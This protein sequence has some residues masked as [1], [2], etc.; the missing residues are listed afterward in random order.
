[1]ADEFAKP[2]F[3]GK[4]FQNP[5]SFTTWKDPPSAGNPGSWR[6]FIKWKWDAKSTK[7]PNLKVLDQT[8]PVL[9]PRFQTDSR[10]SA[11]WLGH[12]TLF[13]RID[14][15]SVLTDPV[16]AMFATPSFLPFFKFCPRFRPPPCKIEELPKIDIVLI[17][18]NHYDHLDVVA[19][20]ELA[21]RF[22]HI[23]WV[24]PLGLKQLVQ[25]ETN[26]KAVHEMN[27]GDRLEL[28]LNERTFEVFSVPAQHWSQRN[29]IDRNTSLW[30][31]WLTKGP[32]HK[33]FFAGDTGLCA[34][35]FRKL[36][37]IHGPIDLSAIPI[38]AYEPRWFLAPQHIDP[39]E[40]V[41][42]HELVKSKKSIAV[43]WGTFE[44]GSYETYLEPREMLTKAVAAAGIEPEAF[45]TLKHGESWRIE[46]RD[47]GTDA[48]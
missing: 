44:M 41:Q 17:S 46:K 47:G 42:I 4:T 25:H 32:Q 38:G 45:V 19:V 29:L 16:W 30:S 18:H 20:R 28:Q 33:F 6:D 1:M 24:V 31:G 13:V 3:D 43:H 12:A 8:L 10:L 40:A 22:P 15:I 37:V 23:I 35:E 14:G 39:K 34:D 11:T 2:K 5:D 7:L 9:K 21:Q 27:W 26:S 36:G 48:Q